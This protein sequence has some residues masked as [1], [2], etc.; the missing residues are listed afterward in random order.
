MVRYFPSSPPLIKV[1]VKISANLW[2][3]ANKGKQNSNIKFKANLWNPGRRGMLTI[4]Y[5]IT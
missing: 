2:S 1:Q 3:M 4:F 5:I